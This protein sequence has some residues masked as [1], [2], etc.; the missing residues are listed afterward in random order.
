MKIKKQEL[1]DYGVYD[2]TKNVYRQVCDNVDKYIPNCVKTN[3][4]YNSL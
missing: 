3:D 1:Q 4:Y 2:L